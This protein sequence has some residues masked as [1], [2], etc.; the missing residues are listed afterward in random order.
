MNFFIKL[1]IIF[2]TFILF[3][4]PLIA[5]I[6]NF[7]KIKKIFYEV[8]SKNEFHDLINQVIFYSF[9]QNNIL[10]IFFM[11]SAF[12]YLFLNYSLRKINHK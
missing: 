1:N 10:F 6:K 3:F 8:K 5:E 2:V 7:Q 9:P 11:V 4:Y 12:Y